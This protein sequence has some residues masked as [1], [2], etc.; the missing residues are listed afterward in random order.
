[1]VKISAVIVAAGM[2]LAALP[3]MA[4]DAANASGGSAAAPASAPAASGDASAAKTPVLVEL[5]TSEGCNTCPP[6]DKVLGY[7]QEKQPFPGT[8]II[9]LEEHVDY[10]NHDGWTD[11]FSSAKWT[12][13]Q[14]DY[15]S[16][17]KKPEPYTPQMIVDGK[18]ELVGSNGPGVIDAVK[19]AVQTPK[20]D[21][22][23]VAG[24]VDSKGVR[25]YTVTT[26]KL[27]GAS[28]GDSPEVWLAVTEDGLQ[29]SVNA[30][31]NSGQTLHHAATMRSLQKIGVA[32]ANKSP[33]SFTGDAAVKFDS[34]WN[35]ANSH[36]VVFIQ[37]KKS[38]EV[39][40]ASEIPLAN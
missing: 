8:T 31:E 21:V 3:V 40:G 6:A 11:P 35:A 12:E 33:E 20:T 23:I 19:S 38:R 10:W 26:G 5:F 9:A 34:K 32:D 13:R 4:Q 16:I 37:E 25:H 28:G 29:S 36:V 15:E 1:M 17:F 2:M 30:G 39:L 22:K 24:T 14:R 18:K 27:V 7:M